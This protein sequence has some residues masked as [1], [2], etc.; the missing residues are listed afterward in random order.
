VQELHAF[1]ELP[2]LDPV[3][4]GFQTFIADLLAQGSRYVYSSTRHRRRLFHEVVLMAKYLGH[5]PYRSEDGE[6][7]RQL[8][9]RKSLYYNN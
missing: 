6:A 8:F 5:L 1:G 9:L 3:P 2:A 4:I 7:Q